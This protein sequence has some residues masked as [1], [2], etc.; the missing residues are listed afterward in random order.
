MRIWRDWED[1]YVWGVDIL[2]VPVL[3]CAPR[4]Q[5]LKTFRVII[6]TIRS[7]LSGANNDDYL[8]LVLNH[9]HDQ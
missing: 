2:R 5:D 8:T 6:R 9:Y 1:S 7:T 3:A 4:S